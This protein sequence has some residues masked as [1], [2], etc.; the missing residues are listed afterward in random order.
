M[1]TYTIYY[2]DNKEIYKNEWEAD[3][4]Q[5]AINSAIDDLQLDMHNNYTVLTQKSIELEQN[6]Y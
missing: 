5:D 2:T 1:N 3:N 6:Q 4:I